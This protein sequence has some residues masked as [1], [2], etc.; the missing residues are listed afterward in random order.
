M[1]YLNDKHPKYEYC[2]YVR[3]GQALPYIANKF[4]DISDVYRFITQIEKRHNH[5]RQIFYIDND[6]YQNKY[7]L[8]AG[9][10]YYKFL[11]RPVFDWEEFSEG[12]VA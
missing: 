6:F 2:L 1:Y 5:Y 7:S 4:S 9:G 12:E 10:T 3:V 8:E 11:R